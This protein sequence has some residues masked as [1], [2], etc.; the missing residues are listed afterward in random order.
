MSI[1]HVSHVRLA[2]GAVAL[3]L[4]F[5]GAALAQP[6]ADAEPGIAITAPE[7]VGV[8][9][10]PLVRMSEWIRK[11]KLDVRSLLV[12]KDGKLIFERYAAGLGREHNY[13]LYSVTKTITALTF[14][15][16]AGQ[17]KIATTDR[18]A[19]WI[20]KTHPQFK[21]ALND[22]K[23]IA[24]GHLMS[25]SSGLLYKQVE[26]SDPLYFQAPDRLKVALS[27]VPRIPPA[28]RFEYTDANPVL[29]G[30]A[31]AAAAGQREDRYAEEQLFKPLGMRNYRWSG[32]DQTGAVSGGWGLRL[33]AIDMAKLGMLMLDEGRWQGRQVVPASWVR[34]MTTPQPGATAQDYGYYCWINHIVESEPEFGAMGFKGQ[35]I[36]VL[37]KQR[38]VVVMTAILPTDGGLRT[39]TYLNMYRRMVNDF[40][41]PAMQT[42]P[43]AQPSDNARQA[44][45]R[46][47]DLSAQ[48][49]GVPGTELAFNDAPEK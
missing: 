1:S 35:F 25:M 30:A 18:A 2:A 46:E 42:L 36:T 37:P 13:E 41:L 39:G 40:I 27:T 10:A 33:R 29:V 4:A 11:D 23:D 15:A 5:A 38:A 48:A 45:K 9:S 28:T 16:L 24:L 12:I 21:D 34:Q 22:K 49:A 20:L 44:L 31:I 3:H 26:G 14:G 43:P 32:A 19:P 47:L 7:A 8:D 17:G 6:A